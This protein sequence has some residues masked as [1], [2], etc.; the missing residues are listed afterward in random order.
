MYSQAVVTETRGASS[1]QVYAD[2]PRFPADTGG[3]RTSC[4][5]SDPDPL[6]S[7]ALNHAERD[8]QASLEFLHRLVMGAEGD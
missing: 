2:V 1:R 6:T 7:D 5:L 8:R 4:V 3:A